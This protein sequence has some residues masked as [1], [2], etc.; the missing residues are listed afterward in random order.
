MLLLVVY[1]LF[2]ELEKAV[3]IVG[4]RGLCIRCSISFVLYWAIKAHIVVHPIYLTV[5][6]CLILQPLYYQTK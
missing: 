2:V 4:G 5:L 6:F 1:R 3:V